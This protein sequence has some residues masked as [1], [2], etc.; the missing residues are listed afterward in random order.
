VLHRDAA[1]EPRDAVDAPPL[2]VSAWSKNQ[3]MPSSGMSPFTRSN[4]SS[5]RPIVSS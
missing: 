3:W 1:A 5:A 4:T 2:I